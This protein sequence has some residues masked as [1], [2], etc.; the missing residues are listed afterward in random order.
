MYSK[1]AGTR[2]YWIIMKRQRRVF[3]ICT[4]MHNISASV[5]GCVGVWV[6]M[7]AYVCI[8]GVVRANTRARRHPPATLPQT[9]A[10]DVFGRP[11][12]PP[13]PPVPRTRGW[14]LMCRVQLARARPKIILRAAAV[15]YNWKIPAA[16][17]QCL[18]RGI[19]N[20]N[21]KE[22]NLLSPYIYMCAVYILCYANVF[23]ILLL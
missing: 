19:G 3:I 6:C 7:C 14:R 5:C 16:Y 17:V 11:P 21:G 4:Y 23:V 8:T 18:F 1:A 9:T 12:P 2:P 13:P 10:A 15:W 20:G 22:K